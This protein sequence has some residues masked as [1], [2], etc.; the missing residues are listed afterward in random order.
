M[1][2][3]SPPHEKKTVFAAGADKRGEAHD[4]RI[5]KPVNKNR[6]E[7]SY[8]VNVQFKYIMHFCQTKPNG[9]D[10]ISSGTVSLVK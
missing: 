10:A 6:V 3:K 4:E 8:K 9:G 2:Y 5:S 1:P 7:Y